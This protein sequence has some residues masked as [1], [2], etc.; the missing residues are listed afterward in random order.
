MKVKP[1]PRY[2]GYYADNTGN[3]YSAKTGELRKMTP[4]YSHNG[5]QTVMLKSHRGSHRTKVHRLIALTFI[6]NHQNK[7]IVCHRDNNIHNNRVGNLY[8]GTQS[9]NMR[10]MVIDGRQRKSKLIH[11]KPIAIKLRLKGLTYKA[12][13]EIL[14]TSV[15]SIKRFIDGKKEKRPVKR[16]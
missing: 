6:P 14:N 16:G 9:D 12:I 2:R 1:I 3:I 4:G 7:P 10:Q 11:L 5:Y 8:W 15:T 13:A